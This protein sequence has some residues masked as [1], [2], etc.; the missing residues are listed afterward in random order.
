MLNKK[1][2]LDWVLKTVKNSI[3]MTGTGIKNI[4]NF[5]FGWITIKVHLNFK[6][7]SIIVMGIIQILFTYALIGRGCYWIIGK[8]IFTIPPTAFVIIVIV[9]NALG[10]A[11][12]MGRKIL[13]ILANNTKINVEIG[14][15]EEESNDQYPD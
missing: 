12:L 7:S 3:K 14:D 6:L 9:L 4:W 11:M 1:I 2:I 5:L 10:V 15:P 8:H 13:T